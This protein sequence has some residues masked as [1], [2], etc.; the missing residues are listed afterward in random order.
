M[1]EVDTL[2]TDAGEVASEVKNQSEASAVAERS[3]PDA[4]KD[5]APADKPLG[6]VDRTDASEDAGEQRR[7]SGVVRSREKIAALE[8]RVAELSARLEAKPDASA[9]P[10]LE[11]YSDF[12]A[13]QAAITRHGVSQALKEARKEEAST[14]LET[15]QRQR[16]E[17]LA[18]DH[19]RREAQAR[20]RIEDYDKVVNAYDGPVA[21]PELRA[22]T[23]ES[24]KSELLLYHFAS[25]PNLVADL[26]R[27]GPLQMAKEV[28][29]I[30][31]RLSYPQARTATN[32]PPPVGGVKGGASP[33]PRFSMSM[34]DYERWR[35]SE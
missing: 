25:R 11:D 34:T 4:K 9:P 22:L 32:A 30:E 16:F 5:N 19:T 18:A 13:Y 24:E 8:A 28:G 15:V 35:A 10:K 17:E 21:R 12:D 2:Q 29:R 23:L 7:K 3:T 27:L 14:E 33:A 6:E 26:N 1:Q 20:E 31:A